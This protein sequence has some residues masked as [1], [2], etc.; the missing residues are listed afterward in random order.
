MN[1][2]GTQPWDVT[3]T[4]GTTP[5]SLIGITQNPYTYTASPSNTSTYAVTS[6]KNATCAGLGSGTSLVMPFQMAHLSKEME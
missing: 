6:V 2:T 5:I 1:F 3:L 4:D